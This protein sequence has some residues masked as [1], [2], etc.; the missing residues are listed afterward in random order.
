MNKPDGDWDKIHGELITFA[1]AE[2]DLPPIDCL[3]GFNPG[4]WCLYERVL[5]PAKAAAVVQPV[6]VYNYKQDIRGSRV[7]EY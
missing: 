6:W 2:L 1:E 4:C 7:A 5:I 3:E